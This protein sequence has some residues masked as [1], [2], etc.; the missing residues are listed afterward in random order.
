[1]AVD[2]SDLDRQKFSAMTSRET[3]RNVPKPRSRGTTSLTKKQLATLALIYNA[4]SSGYGQIRDYPARSGGRDM[5]SPSVPETLDK[6]G[7]ADVGDRKNPTRGRTGNMS[8]RME[9]GYVNAYQSDDVLDALAKKLGFSGRSN[10]MFER[11]MRQQMSQ[12]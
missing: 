6:K 4:G 8:R 3:V 9:G 2:W 7:F 10:N 11:Y 1:M 12:M 5:P